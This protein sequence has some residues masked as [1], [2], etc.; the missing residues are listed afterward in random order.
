MVPKG[1]R[2]LPI[3]SDDKLL[4]MVA[5]MDIIRFFGLG[6]AFRKLQQGTKEMFNTPIIQIAS[7]DILTIDPEEDVGQAAKIMREKDVGVLPVV[8]EKILIGIVTEGGL[9]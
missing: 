2:R 5:A 7:R 4:G 9:L 3:V 8:K 1:F 6:E